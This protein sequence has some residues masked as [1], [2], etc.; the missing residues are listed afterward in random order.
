MSISIR[1]R[2]VYAYGHADCTFD[3]TVPC[4]TRVLQMP[5]R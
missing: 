5:T 2:H 4:L 1:L 3:R